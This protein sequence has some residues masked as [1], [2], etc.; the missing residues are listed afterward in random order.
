M[1]TDPP[2]GEQRLS[3]PE[4]EMI[5]RIRATANRIDERVRAALRDAKAGEKADDTP[6]DAGLS[7]TPDNGDITR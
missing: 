1:P 5:A 3:L 2:T 7:P 4:A 6:L